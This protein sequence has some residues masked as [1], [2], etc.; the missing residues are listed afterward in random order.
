M[1]KDICIAKYLLDPTLWRFDKGGGK[2]YTCHDYSNEVDCGTCSG[3]RCCD[4][5]DEENFPHIYT[6][7]DRFTLI[8]DHVYGDM[9][10]DSDFIISIEL[11]EAVRDK[12]SELD[13]LYI[14]MYD[15]ELPLSKWQRKELGEKASKFFE[16]LHELYLSLQE[17]V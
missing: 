12:K 16:K 5:G 14:Y 15:V 11:I 7:P 10:T 13:D 1:R 4:A 2:V 6:K 9:F 17:G 3:A 8:G